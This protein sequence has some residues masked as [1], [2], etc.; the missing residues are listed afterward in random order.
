MLNKV[1]S[2]IR[3]FPKAITLVLMASM[4]I[5]V[6]A[7]D[8]TGQ[9]PD[10]STLSDSMETFGDGSNSGNNAD[11]EALI[12]EL[13]GEEQELTIVRDSAAQKKPVKVRTPVTG[14]APGLL[15]RSILHGSFLSFNASSPFATSEALFSWY[16]YIDAGV[17]LKLPYEIYVEAIPLFFIF[18]V[19]TF[20]FENS[21]PEGGKFSGLCYIMQAVAIG[22]QAS[23]ALGFG[24]WD[25]ELGSMLELN[26]R[27]RPSKNTFLRVGTRGV[28]ITNIELIG[29]AWWAELRLSLGI[30]L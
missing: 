30:E 19:A 16:S 4:V 11:F 26:Y 5:P 15:K 20:N 8:N 7:Q 17:S 14:P 27:F 12:K 24:Y 2:I 1:L 18:E 23:V 21:Y 10:Q 25:S 13:Y 9:T 6:L 28:L 3:F 29:S 22:D